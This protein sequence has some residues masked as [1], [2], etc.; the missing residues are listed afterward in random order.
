MP[1]NTIP[2]MGMP[3]VV[4]AEYPGVRASDVAPWDIH[5]LLQML[6]DMNA[7]YSALRTFLQVNYPDVLEQFDVAFAAQKRMGV[8]NGN[9]QTPDY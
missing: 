7:S 8:A 9:N 5:R 2:P 4:A 3:S 1:W 6:S